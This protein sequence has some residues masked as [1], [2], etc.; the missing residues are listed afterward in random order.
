MNEYAS[1]FSATTLLHV[2]GHLCYAGK[3]V[4]VLCDDTPASATILL[5]RHVFVQCDD[6]PALYYDTSVMWAG[7]SLFSIVPYLWV[8]IVLCPSHS[9]L[10][11]YTSKHLYDKILNNE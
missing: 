5:G 2:L 6:T 9:L 4:F 8:P 10:L 3:H 7:T 1:L 11:V